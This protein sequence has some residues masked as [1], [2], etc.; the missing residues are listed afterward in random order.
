MAALDGR[1]R[2]RPCLRNSGP[3]GGTR[4][5]GPDRSEEHTSELQS[6]MRSSYAGFCLKK[7]KKNEQ[8]E[9]V[10]KKKGKKQE[11][12]CYL[13]LSNKVKTSQR[14]IERQQNRK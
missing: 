14:D 3:D 8:K 5:D 6:L 13:H 4:V 9:K 2:R 10:S 1:A 11:R 12:I 7:K